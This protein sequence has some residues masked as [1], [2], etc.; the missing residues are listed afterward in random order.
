MLYYTNVSMSLIG[1]KMDP[2]D[3]QLLLQALSYPF[4]IQPPFI[5]VH[6]LNTRPQ[7]LNLLLA[8]ND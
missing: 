8:T 6:F 3:K 4:W 7:V 1:M 5:S 2:I